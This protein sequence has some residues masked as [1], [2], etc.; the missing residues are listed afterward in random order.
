MEKTIIKIL[1]I[2]DN[3]SDVIMLAENLERD[4]LS[5]FELTSVELL[6][7]ALGL[8]Q[9]NRFDIILLDLGL[10]DSFGQETFNSI[11]QAAPDLP[12]IILSGG[13]DEALALD[14]V[15]TGAQDYLVKGPTSW[16]IAARSI[17]YTIERQRSHLAVRESE[18][19]LK[20]FLDAAPDAMIIVNRASK[21]IFGNQ[22][23]EKLFGYSQNELLGQP[24]SMLIPKRFHGRHIVYQAGYLANPH[25]RE[26]GTGLELF[27]LHSDGHEVPVEINLSYHK[28]G[29]ETVVLSAIRDITER[30][31]AEQKLRESEVLLRQVLESIPDSTFA[32]DR[33]YR[34]LINNQRHQ[35]ELVASGGHPFVVGEPMLSPDYPTEILDFWR[36]AYDR[37]LT[38]EIFNLEGSWVDIKG[39]PHTHENRFSPLRNA[40]GAIVGA[41]V[42]AHDITER[43]LAENA[44]IANEKKLRSLIDSQSHFVIRTDMAGNYTYWNEQF[45]KVFGWLHP[46]GIQNTHSLI[47]ICEYH[48]ARAL[49]IVEKC[50]ANPGQ[51]FTVELDNPG[52]NGNIC[53]TLWDFVCLTDEHNQPAEIQCMGTDITERK[54]A[55]KQL[56]E[57]EERL[58]LVMEGSQ[59]GYWDW[60]I[61]TGEVHRNERWAEMLGYT[62]E[63]INYTVKQWTD[64]HHPD[65]RE[66]AWKSIQDHL[67][68]KTPAHR[69]EY[70]MRT[71][72]GQY[73]W[74]L[75]QARVM[76]RDAQGKPL[77]MSGTH[78][79]ITDRKQFEV[80]LKA[81]NERFSQIAQNISD[82]FWVS[83]PVTRKN[84]YISPAFERII[85]F[86]P[87]A[88]ETFP[89][90]FLD[91]ILPEDRS[92]LI[93]ARLQEESGLKTDTQYRIRRP[94]G[95]VRWLRDK[96]APVFDENGKITLVVGLAQ[97]ISGQKETEK[98]LGES[99]ARFRQIAETIDEVFWVANPDIS[100]TIYISPGYERVWG[101]SRESLYSNPQSFIS[102]V[103]PEDRQIPQSVFEL[104]KAG[105]PF[106]HEYRIRHTNGSIRVIWDRG[107]PIRDDTGQVIRYVGVSQD[108]TERKAAETALRES[109]EKYRR[110]SAE[111]EERVKERTAQVQDLYNNAPT[112]YHS[113]DINGRFVLVNQTELG[114]LGYQRSE[115]I[116]APLKN[117]LTEKSCATFD[118]YFPIVQS[119]G[120]ARD[121]ELE[122]VRKDGSLLPVILNATA[123]YDST[124][125][126]VMSRATIMDNTERKKAEL[127][128]LQSRDELRLAYADIERASQAKDD[129][130]ANMSHELRTPLNGVLGISEI[131]LSEMRGPI[132]DHQRKLVSSIDSS[133][134]HLL[135]LIN[136]ILD[137]SKIEAGRLDIHIETISIADAC[138]GSL[139]FVKEPAIK[140]GVALSFIPDPYITSIMA[141]ARRL[142]QMLVNLLSNAVKFTPPQG[143]VMLQVCANLQQGCIEFSVTDTGVGIAPEELA[144]LF[145][146]FT[147][148]DNSLTRQYEGTGLGLALVKRLAEM[149]G[150][151]VHAESVAGKGSTFTVSLPWQRDPAAQDA[152]ADKD[153]THTSKQIAPEKP[154]QAAGTILL[155]EDTETNILTIGDYLESLGYTMIYAY[156]GREVVEKAEATA[157]DLILMDMQM[158]EMNGMDATRI[159]RA[160]PRFAATPIIALTALAMTGDRERFLAAGVNEYLSKPVR[161]KQLAELIQKFLKKG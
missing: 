35:Q 154:I 48:H 103:L 157:P 37:T 138:Q 130:L 119:E 30:K 109:E 9:H 53:V 112:G 44:L 58:E 19:R 11:H 111:L 148:V 78:T 104:Q 126:F 42:V 3:P 46:Q 106:S 99:E 4:P 2:E 131:L 87:E 88:V 98:R 115:L 107:Y 77:R 16:G 74:I 32:L 28:M 123:V 20:G 136:D 31:Q 23:A 156:N 40:T 68:G 6:S 26:M 62:L 147:Q 139:S 25:P 38:G 50:I 5:I 89:N 24:L 29:D 82:I 13:S 33:N 124:G 45:E 118:S 73:K 161:L 132:N 135:S 10:P 141:D 134:R 100:Q 80:E 145:Q 8:L 55:E 7:E 120:L 151:S 27:A 61:E 86:S 1:L 14:A 158:P 70:R 97:D 17:R 39:Q 143:K 76:K 113:L 79:D 18:T 85:G 83:S 66:A 137:L 94:D 95:S 142:K 41:L 96:G 159:L 69:I 51:V 49:E 125:K 117:F 36:K 160:N 65:D 127:A 108:I 122:L 150:G 133:G 90:G 146:P 59:L 102:A 54:Q 153:I 60:N 114:W 72:E 15:Q 12:I 110:L 56:R 140:K 84:I 71:K 101:R 22:Q 91:V 47:D 81:S 52:R 64:L 57:S 75:D 63:E 21:I 116:G 67:D 149:H 155:G 92:I 93:N 144:R 43:K 105:Q 128:L 152:L 121:I 34:L 129:F